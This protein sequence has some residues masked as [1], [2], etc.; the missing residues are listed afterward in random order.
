SSDDTMIK[1]Y[2]N[3]ISLHAM[4]ASKL[5]LLPLEDYMALKQTDEFR[6]SFLRRHAKYCNFGYM[7]GLQPPGFREYARTSFDLELSLEEATA[8]RNTFFGTYTSL[9]LWHIKY[10]NM[11]HRDGQ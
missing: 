6:Y 8:N 5:S 2:K 7:Y 3:G 4:T 10:T 1:S 11:A 9:P